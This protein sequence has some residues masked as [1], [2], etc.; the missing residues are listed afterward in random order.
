MFKP[1]EDTKNWEPLPG[2]GPWREMTDEEY[3]LAK[4]HYAEQ[5]PDEPDALDKWFEEV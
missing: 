4:K 3:A 1:K 2:V 5:F